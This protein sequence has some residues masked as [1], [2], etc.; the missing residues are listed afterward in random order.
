MKNL[1]THE[2]SNFK[3][4]KKK[5]SD[6]SNQSLDALYPSNLDGV[7]ISHSHK[8][9]FSGLSYMNRTI[10]VYA[11]VVTRKI[12][13]AFYKSSKI[14]LNNNFGQLNWI[15][16]RTG[17]ILDIKGL[18][19]VPFHVDHSIPAAYGFII[20]TSVGPVVYTGDFRMHGS[21]SHM[22]REFLEEI[23]SHHIIQSKKVLS[24][25]ERSRIEKGVKVLICEGTKINKSTV[26]SEKEVED[27][28][29]KLFKQNPFDFILVKYDRIDWDRFRTFSHMAKKYQ[30]KYIIS[31]KEAYFYYLLNEDAFHMTMKDPN[32]LTDS[33]I[34]IL[35]SNKDRFKW[36]K[37]IRK[38]IRVN[39]MAYRLITYLEL[40]NL[41]EKYF[42]YITHLSDSLFNHI[43][44]DR[45]GLFISSSVDPY[46]EEFYDN[47]NG[48]RLKLEPLGIPTYR[49]HASGHATPHDLINFIDS[50]RPEML[51]PIHTKHS[52]FFKNLFRNSDI[53]V[54]VPEKYS[55]ININ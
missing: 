38:I 18:K 21:L 46:V 9:H 29:D 16:F 26:E 20:Y 48:I 44:F 13:N 24:K 51:I 30:W 2:F 31:E 3:I 22:S 15:T 32:I 53:K 8:D 45:R 12:I 10:P 25:E 1:Y 23:Q 55:V 35:R 34:L 52:E 41:K 19:I 40:K 28:L 27:N 11:G 17:Q 39:R 37:K 6:S 36:Q 33:H 14:S 54:I 5:C 49:I 50:I 4:R 43:N 42:L 7:L 47:T